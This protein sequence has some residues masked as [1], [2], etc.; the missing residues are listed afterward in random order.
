MKDSLRS[1]FRHAI[2]RSATIG[3]VIVVIIIIVIG[4]YAAVTLA[5]HSASVTTT[6]SPSMS[7]SSSSTVTSSPTTSSSIQVSSSTLA[8]SSILSST[9]PSIS[10]STSFTTSSTRSTPTTFV[11]ETDETIEYLDPTVVYDAYDGGITE[12]VYEPLLQFN[13]SGSQLIPW[14]AQNYTVSANQSNYYFTLRS[15]ISFQDGEPLNSSAVYFSLNRML[16]F[17]GSTP[18]S[19]GTQASWLLQQEENTSL[20]TTLCCAQTYNAQYVQEVLAENFVQ[21]TGPLTFTIHLEQ[22]N[23]AFLFIIAE[24]VFGN[25]M[26]P[27]YVMQHDL[28]LWNQSNSGYTLTYPT[29]SGNEENQIYQYFV[30]FTNTCNAGPTMQGCGET[31]LDTSSGGSMAGTGPYTITSV[32][33]SGNV[34]LQANPNYWG[35]AYQYLGG[36]K[37]LPKIPTVDINVV[38]SVTTRELDIQSAASSGKLMAID[39]SAANLYDIASRAAWLDNGTLQSIVP[40]VRVVGPYLTAETEFEAYSTNV[41]NPVTG[42]KYTFQPFADLRWRLAFAD[43]VNLTEI[44]IDVNNRLGVVAPNLM[45]PGLSPDGSY[46]A[47]LLPAYSYNPDRAAQL[48]LQAMENPITQFTQVN[49]TAASPDEFNNTFGCSSLN[50]QNVCSNPVP[51]SVSLSF[52]SGDT[53]DESIFNQIASVIN[54]I[55]STY[56]MGL[57]VSV[58]PIPS[59]VLSTEGE[60]DELYMY[61]ANWGADYPYATDYLNGVL[62]PGGQYAASD[63]WNLTSLAQLDAQANTASTQGNNSGVLQASQA[64]NVIANKEVMYLWTFQPAFF[65]VMT[66]NIQ[67][68]SWNPFIQL[69]PGFYYYLLS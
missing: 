41:T 27:Q 47:S 36:A 28:A 32:S 31:Y 26:A 69:L 18:V 14:L 52:P 6:S 22:P 3:V 21:I 66:A 2:S 57:T 29:L 55:S 51:Q 60:A 8:T 46:N 61:A 24:Y 59:G 50:A 54:N 39:L 63:G 38:P 68:F 33:P 62:A 43:T 45:D 67:G 11:Y 58:V 15:G 53:V 4:G 9:T 19:H 42:L 64:M 5:S 48:L 40:G 65:G 23:E 7:V 20:S 16:V 30:D 1:K 34:V 37:I 35:G 12:N 17:D 10:S 13:G 25:I 56:N 44:N 49:G